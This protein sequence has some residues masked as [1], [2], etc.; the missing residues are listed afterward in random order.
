MSDKKVYYNLSLKQ[1]QQLETYTSLNQQCN[2]I[3]KE[4]P[5]LQTGQQPIQIE[6][7]K[8]KKQ[9]HDYFVSANISGN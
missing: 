6:S 4:R 1:K 2:V 7:Y 3:Y 8:L 9:M 5:V